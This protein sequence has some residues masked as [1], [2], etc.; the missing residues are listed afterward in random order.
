MSPSD[1][2]F[3]V[4]ELAH[5]ICA[6]ADQND[7]GRLLRVNR[8]LFLCARAFAWKHVT[9][10]IHLFRL[11]P[12]TL[13]NQ[14]GMQQRLVATIDASR[15]GIYVPFIESLEISRSPAKKYRIEGKWRTSPA[16]TQSVPLLPNLRRLTYTGP[17]ELDEDQLDYLTLFLS[18]T[19]RE[20]EIATSSTHPLWQSLP[21]ASKFLESVSRACPNLDHLRIYPGRL[22][23]ELSPSRYLEVLAFTNH[24]STIHEAMGQL[25][26]LRS[27]TISPA[28]LHPDVFC[29]I[30]TYPCLETLAIQ[31]TGYGGPVY[32]QYDLND[33]SF[34]A[35]RHLELV[36]LD[37]HTMER[38]CTLGPLLRRLEHASV[39][40]GTGSNETW[41][42]DGDRVESLYTLVEGCPK[43]TELTFDTGLDGN[44]IRLIPELVD[45]FRPQ[46]LRYLSLSG[47]E[48]ELT[49]LTG[50]DQLLGVLPLVEEFHLPN[51]IRYPELRHF[52]TM[53]PRLRFLAL[54]EVWFDGFDAEKDL[55]VVPNPS[56]IPVRFQWAFH[57]G[58]LAGQCKTIARYLHALWPNVVVEAEIFEGRANSSSANYDVLVTSRM[59]HHLSKLRRSAANRAAMVAL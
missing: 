9:G 32:G 59:N 7:C 1:R 6:L 26:S 8:S 5:T 37:P 21:S 18:P 40:F 43:L 19:V 58:Q 16:Q 57:D 10:A 52:A 11:V 45:L 42:F 50:W 35:L 46:A 20:I 55:E 2:V 22:T 56:L 48:E 39:T 3:N 25:G 49:E 29:V 13:S 14:P 53:L 23:P 17:R 38:L 27:L 36:G 34:P 33:A 51:V 28:V 31:S 12:G 4:P 15:L 47:L 54:M 24:T 41:N 30:A 44:D